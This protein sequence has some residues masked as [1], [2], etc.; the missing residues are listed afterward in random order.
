MTMPIENTSEPETEALC[1]VAL[2]VFEGPLDLLL[3]LVRRHELEILD[4]PIAFVTEKYLE[5]LA[6]MRAM[7]LE[8]AGDYLVMAATL[9]YLKSRELLPPDP[10][11]SD[12]ALDDEEGMD[13]RDALI[14]QLLEYQ[15]F[16]TA[17]AELDSLPVSGRD[18]F[19]RGLDVEL[20][21]VDPGLAP[22]T[23]FRLAE[24]FHRV[25]ERARIRKSHDVVL[26]SVSV[27]ERM[28]QLSNILAQQQQ[29]DFDRLFLDREWASERELRTMLIVT[30][31][32]ILELAKLGIM[33]IHQPQG[34]VSILLEQTVTAEV[35]RKMLEGY[36]E[37]S[38]YGAAPTDSDRDPEDERT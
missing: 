17:A 38:S 21:P 35:A 15:R 1:S 30:L 8:I 12:E 6:L 9:A 3:H 27:A 29:L 16:R 25:L 14:Q 31:M 33:R 20:P 37:A 18:V 4:I 28:E 24:A 10:D 13:P 2:D 11:E 7:D 34:S 26:E 5:Y 36:D 32:S 19:G 22:V 23:L